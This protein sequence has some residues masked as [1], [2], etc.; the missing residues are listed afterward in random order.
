MLFLKDKKDGKDKNKI[1]NTGKYIVFQIFAFHTVIFV[2]NPYVA[3][4]IIHEG[5]IGSV[6]FSLRWKKIVDGCGC[7]L[8]SVL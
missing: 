5:C 4:L 6:I 8:Y 3:L 1:I 7:P 2:I